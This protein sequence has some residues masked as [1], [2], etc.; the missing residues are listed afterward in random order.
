MIFSFMNNEYEQ[1]FSRMNALEDINMVDRINYQ[2][3][4]MQLVILH[5]IYIVFCHND[6]MVCLRSEERR[7]GKEC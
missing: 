4:M 2:P 5:N 6:V 1:K 3:N 7:V